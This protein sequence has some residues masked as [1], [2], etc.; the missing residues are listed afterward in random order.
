[1]ERKLTGCLQRSRPVTLL[2][3]RWTCLQ[4]RGRRFGSCNATRRRSWSAW[5]HHQAW[6]SCLHIHTMTAATEKEMNHRTKIIRWKYS[7]WSEG[8]VGTSSVSE[9]AARVIHVLVTKSR[10]KAKWLTCSIQHSHLGIKL[11]CRH[12]VWVDVDVLGVLISNVREWESTDVNRRGK[13]RGQRSGNVNVRNS[14]R[15]ERRVSA[16]VEGST[17]STGCMG[18]FWVCTR[19]ADSGSS[20]ILYV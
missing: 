5:R 13:R 18:T 9:D 2:Y 11:L 1:M 17:S 12:I 3:L 14:Q 4:A 6:R 20:N 7:P 19:D 15:R 10:M 8:R 16:D